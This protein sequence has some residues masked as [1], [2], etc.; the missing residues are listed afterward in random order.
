MV[1]SSGFHCHGLG[2]VTGMGT[3][4]L[5]AVWWTKK[6]VFQTGLLIKILVHKTFS[7]FQVVSL[8]AILKIHL[9]E[10]EAMNI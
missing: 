8:K 1:R 4:I 2:S 3:E 7:K 9:S 10:A 6:R 5:Q